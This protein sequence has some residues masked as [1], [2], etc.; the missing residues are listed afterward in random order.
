MQIQNHK[1]TE[2]L[3]LAIDL[4][5]ILLTVL[6]YHAMYAIIYAYAYSTM[7]AHI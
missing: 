6:Y 4:D 3:T 1:D 7:H 5:T 2:L